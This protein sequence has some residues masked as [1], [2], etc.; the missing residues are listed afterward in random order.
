MAFSATG[1]L[2]G[3]KREECWLKATV[4]SRVVYRY[5]LPNAGKRWVALKLGANNIC[6]TAARDNYLLP[7]CVLVC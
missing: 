2:C 1:P 4:L 5:R 7:V 6:R 3:E